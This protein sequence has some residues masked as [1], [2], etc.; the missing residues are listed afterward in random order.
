MNYRRLG[1]A[2]VKVSEL[3]LG[4]WVTFGDQIAD[5][6]AEALMVRAYDGGINFFDNAEGYASGRSESVMGKILRKLGWE[7]DTWLVSSKVFFG[8]AEHPQKP[9]QNGLSRKH[10]FEACHAAL[11]RL[12]VDYLDLFFCHRPDPDTPMEETVRAMSDLIAQGKVLYWG[13]SVWSADEIM[14]ATAVAR[15]YHLVAPTMEQPYYNLLQRNR[16]EVEY[17]RLYDR[18]GLGTTIWSPLASGLLT[19]K[20]NDGL[21]TDA[22][23]GLESYGWLRDWVLKPERLEKVR[24]FGKLAAELG[25]PQP[26]LAIAWCLKNPHVSTVILGASKTAQLEQNLQASAAAEKLTP[27]LLIQI[28]NIMGTKPKETSNADNH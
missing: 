9:N 27:E 13:T 18:I 2:G 24:H 17:A 26:V 1:K 14:E 7:R 21:P 20:Y 10:I 5:D 11:K 12:Q 3:S 25:I 15:K 6:V 8:S 19:G 22:R 23:L 28:D 16:V 4:S